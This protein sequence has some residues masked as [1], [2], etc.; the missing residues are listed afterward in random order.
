M[1][2]SKIEKL[3]GYANIHQQLAYLPEDDDGMAGRETIKAKNKFE[4][5]KKHERPQ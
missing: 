4:G 5:K 3:K 2:K 1:K